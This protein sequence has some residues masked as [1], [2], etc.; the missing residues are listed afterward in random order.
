MQGEI[1]QTDMGNNGRPYGGTCEVAGKESWPFFKFTFEI[2]C[3]DL[4]EKPQKFCG[5]KICLY[6]L[7]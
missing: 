4:Q 3:V 2:K 1:I 6:W 5:T 7:V